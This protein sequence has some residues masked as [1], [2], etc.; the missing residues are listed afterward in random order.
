[1]T[2]KMQEIAMS[3]RSLVTY[4]RGKMQINR[5][6]DHV[7]FA[8]YAI[9]WFMST[10]GKPG[11]HPD[12]IYLNQITERT[13][14]PMHVVSDMVRRLN[15]HDLIVWTHDGNWE[16]GTYVQLSENGN[17]A[18]G[19]QI[20]MLESFHEG[21]IE[22]FGEDRFLHLLQEMGEL[23]ELLHRKMEEHNR[24]SEDV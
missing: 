3:L 18:I 6:F 16:E 10:Y 17:R 5:L 22:E 15:E 21:V 20:A 8:D 2:Q 13:G 1:M 19:E 23:E 12:K 7:S 4:P 11:S 24:G 9:L 14:M